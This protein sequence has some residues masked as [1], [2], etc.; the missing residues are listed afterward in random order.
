[1]N[2]FNIIDYL[3][4]LTGFV[5]SKSV[6]LRVAME[7]DVL[8]VTDISQIDAKTKDLLLAD[9]LLVV[10]LSPNSSASLTKQHGAFTHTIGS[11]TTN[12]KDDIYDVICGIYKKY[13]DE[14]IS[15]LPS[16][17]GNLTWLE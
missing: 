11:Q 5:F 13:G 7:R 6:L 4:G 10:Y 14:K 17:S 2:E 12:S 1:M 9:L 8:G 3:S 16:S 15:S